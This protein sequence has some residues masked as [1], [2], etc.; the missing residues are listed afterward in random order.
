MGS[1][2]GEGGAPARTGVRRPPGGSLSQIRR[3]PRCSGMKPLP[4]AALALALVGCRDR[5]LDVPVLSSPPPLPLAAPAPEVPACA[6]SIAAR[7]LLGAPTT[8]GATVALVRGSSG[9][10]AY[11]ADEDGEAIRTV[12]VEAGAEVA[13]TPLP[14]KPGQILATAD[15]RLI[16]ALRDEGALEVLELPEDRRAP[17]SHRCRIEAPAEPVGLAAT[18]DGETLLVTSRWGHALTT[19]AMADGRR[20]LSVDL[21]RDPYGVVA[22]EDGKKAIVSHTAGARLSVVDLHTAVART[23]DV[24]AKDVVERRLQTMMA[25]PQAGKHAL[26]R[27]DR[28]A[29]SGSQAFALVRAAS[30]RILAPEVLVETGPATGRAGGYGDASS[31]TPVVAGDVS[32]IDAAGETLH[33]APLQPGTGPTDC[34]LPRAAAMDERGSRLLVS[35][36]GID[37]VVAYAAAKEHPHDS[38]LRRWKVPAGP[39]GI[40]VDLAT[41]RAVVWSQFDGAVSVIALD[42]PRPTA[43]ARLIPLARLAP[44]DAEKDLGRRLFHSAGGRRI[45]ADG[46]ACASCHPDGRDDALTWSSPEGPR[47]TPM[48]LGRLDGTA[49]Y[50]WTGERA[51]LAGH[52]AR[53]L[54]RLDGMGL[55]APERDAIF[56]YVRSLEPPVRP[57]GASLPAAAAHGEAL[58]HDKETGCSSCHLGDD[59]TTD[60][61]THDVESASVFDMVRKFDTPSLRFIGQTAPY[62]HDGRYPT[63]LALL[64]GADGTMG[65]TRQLSDTDL[66]DL[67]AYLQT[68]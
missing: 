48:L 30:G 65:H 40:A 52:F 31:S 26:P 46:R 24:V 10:L 11:V 62:F 50:G 63:L 9:T 68:L 36:L 55:R 45:A 41:Q 49:P 66:A 22:S 4:L 2:S 21:P 67:T 12:D 39:T 51:D 7:P 25:P 28:H 33:L 54:E 8:S 29:R 13:T 15:G 60:H 57:V 47:Q 59:D 20:L 42:D 3:P 38:E 14:G 19:Y 16:V 34:L 64:Q 18:P 27:V 43:Q 17:L 56:A 35:C 44:L 37:S 6:R 1:P 5:R 32:V 58:F 53:T 61:A 23:L